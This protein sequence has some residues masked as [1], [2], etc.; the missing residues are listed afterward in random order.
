MIDDHQLWDAKA[1]LKIIHQKKEAQESWNEN[2]LLHILEGWVP[3]FFPSHPA[4]P[5]IVCNSINISLQI[6]STKKMATSQNNEQLSSKPRTPWQTQD[7][8]RKPLADRK[9]ALTGDPIS[10]RRNPQH[11]LAHDILYNRMILSV[12]LQKLHQTKH[13]E[14]VLY[15]LQLLQ[16]AV[17]RHPLN[18]LV[19]PPPLARRGRRR[20]SSRPCRRSWWRSRRA[21][22]SPRG[23][24]AGPPPRGCP[25]L[26]ASEAE[27]MESAPAKPE[28]K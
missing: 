23:T 10:R 3:S 4:D 12:A 11:S 21:P 18:F 1:S 27:L 26:L 17:V 14:L 2:L 13:F 6:A 19:P 22:A 8:G 28:K 15:I 25:Q 7:L 9:A 20:S 16:V 24:S 5:V